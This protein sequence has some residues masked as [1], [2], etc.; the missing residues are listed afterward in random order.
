MMCSLRFL[1]LGIGQLY[2]PIFLL[3]CACERQLQSTTESNKTYLGRH[4]SDVFH[5]DLESGQF[6]QVMRWVS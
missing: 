3:R 4:G 1:F 5:R 2:I 6:A